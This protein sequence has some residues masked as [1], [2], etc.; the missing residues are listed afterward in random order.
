M[1]GEETSPLAMLLPVAVYPLLAAIVLGL[2]IYKLDGA[3]YKK[4]VF[5]AAPVLIWL[6]WLTAAQGIHTRWQFPPRQALDWFLLMTLVPVL[7]TRLPKNIRMSGFGIS[8]ML[9]FALV[10]QPLVGRMST[11]DLFTHLVGWL[12]LLG[13]AILASDQQKNSFRFPASLLTMII[14]SAIVIGI[15]SSL[16]LAQMTGAV[17]AVLGGLWLLARVIRLPDDLM[18][19]CTQGAMALWILVLAYAHYYADVNIYALV[20]L[21]LPLLKAWPEL[22]STDGKVEWKALIPTVLI[23][24]STGLMALWMVWP[25]QSLF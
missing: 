2:V 24:A 1:Y 25:A 8:S 19:A 12:L 22:T 15:S 11:I 3:G 10:A 21:A 20:I 9:A 17:A 23:S 6:A 5:W 7:A 13:V 14:L 16:A 18:L 4:A